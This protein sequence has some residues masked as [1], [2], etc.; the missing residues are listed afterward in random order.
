MKYKNKFEKLINKNMLE[1]VIFT[2]N[3][4]SLF[5]AKTCKLWGKAQSRC[6]L[7]GFPGG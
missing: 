7:R 4:N 5:Y 1:D 6:K 3:K 2:E